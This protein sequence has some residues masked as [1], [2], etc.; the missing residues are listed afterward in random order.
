MFHTWGIGLR[1]TLY[2]FP[3][4][5]ERGQ[6]SLCRQRYP[7]LG[8]KN[9]SASIFPAI[10][11]QW[12]LARIRPFYLLK[13]CC[14]CFL[15]SGY[16]LIISN[17]STYPQKGT[18]FHSNKQAHSNKQLSAACS[19]KFLASTISILKNPLFQ[20]G[21]HKFP[22]LPRRYNP[23]CPATLNVVPKALQLQGLLSTPKID[24]RASQ[25]HHDLCLF[26]GGCSFVVQ[27]G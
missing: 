3:K 15:D 22:R 20:Q 21:F 14:W 19:M 9:V 10:C 16:L 25:K 4:F 24:L 26:K 5:C 6:Y 18:F 27:Y 23:N 2:R 8:A 1:R 11:H 13:W 12:M 7:F 17:I